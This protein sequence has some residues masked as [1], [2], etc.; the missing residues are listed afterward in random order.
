MPR[1]HPWARP[2][3][4]CFVAATSVCVYLGVCV[5]TTSLC[6]PAGGNR[7]CSFT[8]LLFHEDCCGALQWSAKKTPTLRIWTKPVATGDCSRVYIC[9]AV[10]SVISYYIL[11][12]FPCFLLFVTAAAPKDLQELECC[13][14][15]AFQEVGLHSQALVVRQHCKLGCCHTSCRSVATSSLKRKSTVPSVAAQFLLIFIGCSGAGMIILHWK[16]KK[17]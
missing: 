2:L 7:N 13:M 9:S 12:N 16:S 6:V 5:I 17:Y 8:L 4:C 1:R 14:Y 15:G 11:K 3:K 10:F